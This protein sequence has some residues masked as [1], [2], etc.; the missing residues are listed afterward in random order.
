MPGMRTLRSAPYTA[1]WLLL[2]LT[3]VVVASVGSS[4]PWLVLAALVF[5]PSLVLAPFWSGKTEQ[6]LS[7][8][9]QEA[10]R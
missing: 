3:L 4:P 10:L 7:Q 8:R 5:L 1:G 9:I 6:S 2:V